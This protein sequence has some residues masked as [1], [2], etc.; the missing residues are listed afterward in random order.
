MTTVVIVGA[1][2]F[3]GFVKIDNPDSNIQF[4]NKSTSLFFDLYKNIAKIE[5]FGEL[6]NFAL[7]G[8]K[9]QICINHCTKTASR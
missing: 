5:V 3:L 4:Y 2:S 9:C 7:I 8:A 6:S 1:I